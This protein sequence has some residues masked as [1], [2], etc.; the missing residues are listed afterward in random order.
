[1]DL[2]KKHQVLLD[3]T[4]RVRAYERAIQAIVQPG[5]IV[6][7]FGCGLG[8]LSMTAA[9]AGA[10][11][12]HAIEVEP[13]TLALAQQEIETAGFAATMQFHEGLA[14]DLEVPERVDVVV[15][16]TLGSLG[17]DENILPLLLHARR[18]WLKPEGRICPIRLTLTL[19]PTTFSAKTDDLRPRSAVIAPSTFLAAPH[20]SKPVDFTKTKKNTFVTELA[21]SVTHNGTLRGFAGWF[22]VWLTEDIHF[23]TGPNDPPT[24]WQQAFLP[25]RNPIP[26]RAGQRINFILGIGPDDS[27]L[28]SVIEYDFLIR[29]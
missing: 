14:Q 1:M 4:I 5:D 28:E 21:F 2:R 10:A 20:T 27:G 19:A 11:R 22:E 24:H 6:A 9:R 25:I 12:V 7:D 29:N 3:D 13:N 26:L 17:L 18:H 23:A 15:T 16:E 8:I